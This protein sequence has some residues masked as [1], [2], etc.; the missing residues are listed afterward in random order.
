[1]EFYPLTTERWAD[2]EHLFGEKGACGGC[3]CMW[4]R[5]S[6]SEFIK[7][8]GEKNKNA[9][10]EIVNSGQIPGILAYSNEIPI[11]WCAL[12]PRET[13]T[14]LKRSKIL[15]QIDDKPVWSIVCFF[16]KKEYRRKGVSFAL[17]NEALKYIEKQGGTIVEGY[18]IDPKN[19]KYADAF[20]YTGLV[21]TFLKAGFI[22]IIRRSK[23]RPIMRFDIS[24]LQE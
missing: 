2:L 10:K 20:A 21:S 8:K 7:K 9:L 12:S 13:F 1:L 22:E 11:G 18:P 16:I 5:S 23:T 3:W 6:H 4:W 17:L 19:K 24:K 14:R 15:K